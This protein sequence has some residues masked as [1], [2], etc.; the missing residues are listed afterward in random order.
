MASLNTIGGLHYEMMKRCYNE[1]SIAYKD[2]GAKGIRV[3]AEWHERENFRKWCNENGYVKGMRIERIDT[4]GNYE[5]SN[6]RFGTKHI[7]KGIAKGIKENT[8]KNRQ[9]KMDAGITGKIVEDE[10]YI[11]YRGMRNRCEVKSHPS[12]PNYGG[13]GIRVC[14]EWLG[15]DGFF[16]FKKW[17]TSNGWN[18]GLS[19]DRIDNNKGYCPDNCRF[20][21]K[22]E[23]NYHRRSNIMYEYSGIMMPLGMIAKLEDV[24]YGLL[25]TRVRIKGMS[26][27]QAL[28]DIKGGN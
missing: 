3:C 16:N 10:L 11:C 28:E 6:C 12:Y 14:E 24:K 7:D 13:R 18:K 15:K 23:Q 5:P 26:V 21:T 2:Y 22:A 19:L 27:R 1:K 9:K 17:S 25:Y 4:K 8:Q 20:V